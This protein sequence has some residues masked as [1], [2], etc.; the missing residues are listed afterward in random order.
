MTVITIHLLHSN[1]V[2]F[3]ISQNG[4]PLGV[5]SFT[6]ENKSSDCSPIEVSV[7]IVVFFLKIKEKGEVLCGLTC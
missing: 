6:G 3:L 1:S 2:N 5:T 7:L 4:K